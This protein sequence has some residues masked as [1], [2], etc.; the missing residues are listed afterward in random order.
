MIRST[1]FRTEIEMTRWMNAQGLDIADVYVLWMNASNFWTVFY[2][3]GMGRDIIDTTDG[4]AGTAYGL[5]TGVGTGGATVRVCSL[6]V[7]VPSEAAGTPDQSTG[8]LGGTVSYTYVIPDSFSI[9]DPGG[10]GFTV[11]DDG[12]GF[13]VNAETG[14]QVGVIDYATGNFTVKWPFGKI[15]TGAVNATYT[16]SLMPDTDNV[17]V[18]ARL[19]N[20]SLKLLS[21]TAAT[22]GWAIYCDSAKAH[23]PSAV[24]TIT[25]TNGVGAANLLMSISNTLDLTTRDSRWIELVPNTG[26]NNLEVLLTWERIL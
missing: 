10:V 21:G 3:D 20:L 17:P 23:P 2:E 11:K 6:R 16:Y 22:V 15:P 8:S 1:S 5:A 24:G 13:L 18:R 26:T 9:S 12:F 4:P 19:S 7:A 14:N 25:L